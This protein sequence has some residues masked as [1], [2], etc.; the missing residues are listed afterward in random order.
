MKVQIRYE[1]NR[2]DIFDTD[3]FTKSEP[4]DGTTMLANFEVRMDTLGNTGLWLMVHHYDAD[5]AYAK[6]AKEGET[7]VARRRRGWRFLLAEA[8][9]LDA[10]ECVSIDSDP[11]LMRIEGELV[12]MVRF[13]QMCSLWI[14]D[15]GEVCIV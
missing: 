1:N 15:P 8:G 7:P 4:F 12:D 5:E 14:P 6:S 11:I 13:D 10:I 3:T 9:E 2:L